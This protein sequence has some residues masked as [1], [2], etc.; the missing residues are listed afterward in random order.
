MDPQRR[1]L[2][3]ILCAAYTTCCIA[4]W[5]ITTQMRRGRVH[6]SIFTGAN[7][8]QYLLSGHP[9]KCFD[10][11]RME[12]SAFISLCN[13]LKER[14]NIIDTIYLAIDE[15]V[16]IFLSTITHDQRN[17]V[18]QERFQHSRQTIS[19]FF[20]RVLK[21]ILELESLFL[22]PPSNETPAHIAG[23]TLRFYPYFKDCVGA[24]DGILMG[25]ISLLE[26][27]LDCIIVSE[28]KKVF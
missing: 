18:V 26:F 12:K 24:I 9:R 14:T 21:A 15:Q 1:R 17:R 11:L 19:C 23:D 13:L 8:V 10:R 20:N 7:Y 4:Y 5:Y 28:T 3:V 25:F 22:Q 6:T 2:V 16:A 27:V